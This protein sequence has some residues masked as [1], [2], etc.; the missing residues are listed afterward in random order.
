ME[1]SGSEKSDDEKPEKK[2]LDI[3]DNI[4]SIRKVQKWGTM[5]S[6][7]YSSTYNQHYKTR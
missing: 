4:V 5:G 1:A 6:R 7:K 3:I 2:K